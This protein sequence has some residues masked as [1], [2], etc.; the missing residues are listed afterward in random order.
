MRIYDRQEKKTL[1]TDSF[2]FGDYGQIPIGFSQSTIREKGMFNDQAHYHKKGYEFYYVIEGSG[3]LRVKEKDVVL[4]KNTLVMVEPEEVHHI[5]EAQTTPFSFIAICT[6]KER[7]D[8]V[9]I[10]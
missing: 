10:K 3:V 6:V 8:K 9:I 5:T 7:D 4:D 1:G 2:Y